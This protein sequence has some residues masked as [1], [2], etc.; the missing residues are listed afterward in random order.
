MIVKIQ[1]WYRASSLR[2]ESRRLVF[3][4]VLYVIVS[5]PPFR[6]LSLWCM[7]IKPTL[8]IWCICIRSWVP[9][10]RQL[11]YLWSLEST[12]LQVGVICQYVIV[13][14]LHKKR[15]LTYAGFTYMAYGIWHMAYA[16][17]LFMASNNVFVYLM[18]YILY[19]WHI[20]IHIHTYTSQSYIVCIMYHNN[21]HNYTKYLH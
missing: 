16:M 10:R 6:T 17:Y 20:H 15:L 19:L 7:C 2:R 21:R 11:M 9:W 12:P 5:N 3:R 4:Y 1:A 13:I 18:S 8:F 14:E